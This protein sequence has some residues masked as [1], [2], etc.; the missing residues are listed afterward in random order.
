VPIRPVLVYPH[1]LLKTPCEPCG[2]IDHEVLEVARDLLDTMR[3][4]PK[5]V[6]LAAPQIGVTKRMIAVDVTGHPK[7]TVTHGQLVIVDPVIVARDGS[8]I[9]REGCLSLPDITADVRRAVRIFVR[10]L[11]IEGE[12]ASAETSGFEARVIQHE[13]D[14]LDGI[15]IL[16]RVA[17]PSEVFPRKRR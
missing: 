3:S 12:E 9:G 5:T 6:G 2:D 13:I 15:L 7:A 14:H 11:T 17:S 16:D 4:Y 8:E 10:G 1:P